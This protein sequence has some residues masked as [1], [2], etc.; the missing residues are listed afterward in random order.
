MTVAVVMV[1][2]ELQALIKRDRKVRPN[3]WTARQVVG[4][5]ERVLLPF[6]LDENM[7]PRPCDEPRPVTEGRE[8]LIADFSQVMDRR[9]RIFFQCGVGSNV[10]VDRPVPEFHERAKLRY[11][12]RLQDVPC[13]QRVDWHPPII[14]EALPENLSVFGRTLVEVSQI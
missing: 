1:V 11:R 3:K 9:E 14:E 13:F 8:L 12:F 7:T 5:D 2:M 6:T 4:L 10:E